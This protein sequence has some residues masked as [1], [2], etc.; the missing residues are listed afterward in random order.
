MGKYIL[1]SHAGSK[2]HGC[3]ALL[4]TSCMVIKDVDKVYS[5]SVE[6]DE[7][8]GLQKIVSIRADK[9]EGFDS[10]VH[11]ILYRIK[12]TILKD[13]R[14]YF[15]NLYRRFI[16][17]IDPNKIY[18]SIGGD[19]YCYHFSGWLEVLNRA[20]NK[21]NAKSVLWGCSINEDEFDDQNVLADL[22]QYT[23]I[24]ARESLTYNTLKKYLPN[25]NVRF[26]PDT[27]FLLPVINKELPKGFIEGNTVGLNVSPIVQNNCCGDNNQLLLY[28]V[29]LV[30]YL[31]KKT[32]YQIALIPHVVFDGNDDREVLKSIQNQCMNS[33]RTVLIQDDNCMVLK[34]IISRCEVFI[35]ARTHATIAA[36]STCVPTLV[37]G[38]SVKS[39]GIA[40]DLFGTEENYVIPVQKLNSSRQLICFLQALFAQSCKKFL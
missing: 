4:R 39:R 23:L 20:I 13:D 21:R 27:A 16:K 32:N 33:E 5:G 38:Y 17:E 15:K 14:I 19:N 7:K 36:Y 35:G 8:Y 37:M 11:E 10:W 30:N 6:A 34:G 12:Y 28:I 31:I 2:N 9:E 3:E 29:E 25:G 22:K 24:T 26:V 18:I 40:K 1:Y